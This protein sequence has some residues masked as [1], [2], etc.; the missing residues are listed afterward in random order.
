MGINKQIRDI[1]KAAEEAKHHIGDGKNISEYNCTICNHPIF[2]HVSYGCT[3][4]ICLCRL[5]LEAAY[6]GQEEKMYAEIDRKA[7]EAI[8]ALKYASLTDGNK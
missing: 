8:H 2:F 4:N 3:A 6:T 5:S 7:E 1:R